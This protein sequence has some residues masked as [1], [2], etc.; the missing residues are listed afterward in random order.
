MGV[1]THVDEIIGL[2]KKI[3][4]VAGEGGG[5]DSGMIAE[6]YDPNSTTPI[7]VGDLKVHEN[8]LYRC[9]EAIPV[10]AGEF[11][12]TMWNQVAAYDKT[13][14][15]NTGDNVEYSSSVYECDEDNVTGEFDLT[16]WTA[17]S[18]EYP[19]YDEDETYVAGVSK[20]AYGDHYYVAGSNYQ[21]GGTVGP[22]N[23]SKWDET[24]VEEELD[25]IKDDINDCE[26]EIEDCM[27][28]ADMIADPYNPEKNPSDH[29]AYRMG[30]FVTYNGELYKAN[31]TINT[32]AGAFN[33]DMWDM[34]TTYDTQEQYEL[35]DITVYNG[36]LYKC[37]SESGATGEWDATKWEIQYPSS[38]N[39]A[40]S[41]Y[42][43]GTVVE[44]NGDYYKAN[45]T[46]E[47]APVGAFDV[48]KWT[49][50]TVASNIG[51]PFKTFQLIRAGATA[52]TD[53]NGYLKFS[54]TA[55]GGSI[56]PVGL[57]ASD[58]QPNTGALFELVRSSYVGE[59]N[60]I[61]VK[62]TD[63]TGA[64]MTN[65]TLTAYMTGLLSVVYMGTGTIT[66]VS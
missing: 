55:T 26:E 9:K 1:I 6:T 45:A 16:K 49:N 60:K 8:K 61:I 30:D 42:T 53:A 11:D 7:A 33:G 56:Y 39:Q 38:Y 52:T 63:N 10:N 41:Y 32:K 3:K 40:A 20:V 59:G 24:T 46:Y 12:P 50:T 62:V 13:V 4:A 17:V 18:Y 57:S 35:D 21:Q 14:T 29:I 15:Y 22:F 43:P 25:A 23:P 65:A 37:I 51:S 27:H 44:Y 2:D 66:A 36:D 48:L 54:V 5:A 47:N 31:Q 58:T 34:A 28:I 19:L 64:A